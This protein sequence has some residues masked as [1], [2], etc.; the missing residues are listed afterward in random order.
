MPDHAEQ[1]PVP[2]ANEF[3]Q[4]TLGGLLDALEEA[5]RP[6]F[7]ALLGSFKA[8]K[9]CKDKIEWR[10]LPWRWTVSITRAGTER[11][12]VAYLIAR[13]GG[14]FV[15][16][17]VPLEGDGVPAFDE[18]TKPVRARIEHS[19]IIAGYIWTEWPLADLDEVAIKPLLEARVGESG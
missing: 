12:A 2:W 7:E 15:C 1:T 10:G 3:R 18:L 14:A 4:P 16:I 17:P 13:P 19:P 9:G 8:R 5:E 11:P 6:A